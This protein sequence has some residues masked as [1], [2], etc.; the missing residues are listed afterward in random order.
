[1]A[2]VRGGGWVPF[3]RWQANLRDKSSLTQSLLTVKPYDEATRPSPLAEG[4]LVGDGIPAMAGN[5][6]FRCTS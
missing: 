3:L 2:E 4:N 6:A 5:R 1:M